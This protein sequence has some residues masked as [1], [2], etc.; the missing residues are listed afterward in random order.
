MKPRPFPYAA[1]HPANHGYE[2]C[3]NCRVWRPL[4]RLNAMSVC[5]AGCVPST[6]PSH[7]DAPPAKPA[8]IEPGTYDEGGKRR[9]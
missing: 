4:E 6:T 7:F 2:Q 5:G 3:A 8:D 9:G 1:G